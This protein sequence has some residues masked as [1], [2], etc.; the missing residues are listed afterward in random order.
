MRGITGGSL[1]E[2]GDRLAEENEEVEEQEVEGE[3]AV[4][5]NIVLGVEWVILA[6]G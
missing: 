5:T 1:G 4:G 3:A 6:V 2:L